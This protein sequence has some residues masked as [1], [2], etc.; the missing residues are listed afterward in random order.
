M[1]LKCEKN[2][3]AHN[4]PH[5]CSIEAWEHPESTDKFGACSTSAMCTLK[6]ASAFIWS[7]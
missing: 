2:N 3:R 5:S 7:R 6:G 1:D 4:Q